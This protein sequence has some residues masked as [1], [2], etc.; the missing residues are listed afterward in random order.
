MDGRGDVEG[1]IERG[2]EKRRRTRRGRGVKDR[3]GEEDEEGEGVRDREGEE[4][5]E[6]E[7]GVRDR[8]G[9]EDEEGEDYSTLMILSHEFREGRCGMNSFAVCGRQ[10]IDYKLFL[11][12]QHRGTLS[13]TITEN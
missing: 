10:H 11:T 1:E 13:N 2:R 4:D 8:E 7:E 3:E 9:E 6:V 5:E 12:G